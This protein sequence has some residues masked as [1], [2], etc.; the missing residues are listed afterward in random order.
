MNH[1]PLHLAAFATILF[2][3]CASQINKIEKKASGGGKHSQ[4]RMYQAYISG[5]KSLG[6]KRDT[7]KAHSW[8]ELAAKNENFEARRTLLKNHLLGHNGYAQSKER[9]TLLAKSYGNSYPSPLIKS[10]RELENISSLML[11]ANNKL[12]SLQKGLD[13]DLN[14]ASLESKIGIYD[15]YINSAG[16]QF[17]SLIDKFD[18][19]ADRIRFINYLNSLGLEGVNYHTPTKT[20][21]KA[22]LQAREDMSRVDMNYRNKSIEWQSAKSRVQSSINTANSIEQMKNINQSS[23]YNY[24][25]YNSGSNSYGTSYPARQ[26]RSGYIIPGAQ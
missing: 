8:L 26:P 22:L 24:G 16:S 17:S 23:S 2:S 11:K 18:K 6:V 4:Y 14:G 15:R 1:I 21:F 7:E 25:G 12:A 9:A 20:E 5:D 19:T 3:S 10:S 13:R